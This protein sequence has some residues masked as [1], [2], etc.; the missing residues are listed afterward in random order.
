MTKPYLILYDNYRLGFPAQFAES[1][2]WSWTPDCE[3]SWEPVEKFVNDTRKKIAVVNVFQNNHF[4]DCS[5]ASLVIG[6]TPEIVDTDLFV[7]DFISRF[8]QQTKCSH[9]IILS[10]GV[11]RHWTSHPLVY[12]PVLSSFDKICAANQHLKIESPS[13][14]EFLFEA[15][16][17]QATPHRQVLSKWIQQSAFID[18]TLLSVSG[19]HGAEHF[20]RSP[21]LD[22]FDHV[23]MISTARSN[24]KDNSANYYLQGSDCFFGEKMNVHIFIPYEIYKNSWYSIVAETNPTQVS[25][26][27]TEKTGKAL[28]GQRVFVLFGG[29]RALAHLRAQGYRTFEG[30]IDESYDNI[31]NDQ[32]R[33]AKAWQTVESL[34]QSNPQLLY[35]QAQEILFHNYQ[36]IRDIK[37]RHQ[38]IQN[39]ISSWLPN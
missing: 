14:R 2:G 31:W 24:L 21:A 34:A 1:H 8:Q 17:G 27:H 22:Q 30:L 29:Y 26:F 9:V 23:Q 32:E 36:L 16:L 38:P 5:W 4:K 3:V 15:L 6:Y 37:H 11:M 20:Y 25:S 10:G 18:S 35:T 39:F 13:Q 7:E 19:S 28:Y 33:W 12:V